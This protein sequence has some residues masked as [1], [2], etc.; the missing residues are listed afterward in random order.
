MIT[1]GPVDGHDRTGEGRGG[2]GREER[3]EERGRQTNR[4]GEESERK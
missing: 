3:N 1:A 4:R 2:G